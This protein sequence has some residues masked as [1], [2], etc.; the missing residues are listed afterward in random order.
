MNKNKKILAPKVFRPQPPPRVLQRK[1]N[2]H[3]P[4]AVGPPNARSIQ[5][6]CGTPGCNDPNCHDPSNHG[7]GQ[8]RPLRGRTIYSGVID[9]SDIGSGSGTSQGTRNYVNSNSTPYPEQVVIEYGGVGGQHGSGG[10]SEFINEPLRPGQRADAGH[11]FGRQYGGFGNQNPSVFSQNPQINRGNYYNGEPTR[12]MWREHEDN[13]R[14]RAQS[15]TPMQ[16]AVTLRD[17]ERISYSRY[18]R[19][20]LTIYPI[21][22]HICAHCGAIL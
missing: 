1:T 6:N 12:H 8:V 7:F 5:R 9:R 21:G 4:V 10:R 2:V 18:C 22:A 16:V 19:R 15:G 14:H 17:E 13:I 3:R 20:C 11:I